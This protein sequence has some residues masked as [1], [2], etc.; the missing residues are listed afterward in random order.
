MSEVYET[1]AQYEKGLWN[2]HWLWQLILNWDAYEK[3]LKDIEKQKIIDDIE[4]EKKWLEW[5]KQYEKVWYTYD[6]F[7]K[8]LIQRRGIPLVNDLT[9]PNFKENET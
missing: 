3:K 9:R 7:G 4:Q 8:I 1:E 6:S 5:V 2:D